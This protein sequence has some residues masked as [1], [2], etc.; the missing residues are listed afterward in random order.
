MSLV[1][2]LPG[3][4]VMLNVCTSPTYILTGRSLVGFTLWQVSW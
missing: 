1:Y 4:L 3:I 2:P